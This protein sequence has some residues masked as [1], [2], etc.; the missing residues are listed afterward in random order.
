MHYL[1]TRKL[2]S[3]SDIVSFRIFRI[4][5]RTFDRFFFPRRISNSNEHDY[6]NCKITTGRLKRQANLFINN[7]KL[8]RRNEKLQRVL[9]QVQKLH[10]FLNAGSN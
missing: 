5:N 1:S 2:E 9:S 10:R 7:T 8:H 4:K 6:S 3:F